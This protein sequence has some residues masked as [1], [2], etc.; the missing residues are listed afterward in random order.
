MTGTP[1]AIN[2]NAFAGSSAAGATGNGVSPG[3]FSS[4]GANGSGGAAGGTSGNPG[5]AGSGSDSGGG[6]GF[7]GTGGQP[8]G[9]TSGNGTL[10]VAAGGGAG[11]LVITYT[12][13]SSTPATIFRP[14]RVITMDW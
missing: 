2:G 10:A 8:G 4:T 6:G 11:E 7:H 5:T 14:N 3:N 9:A 1:G 13:T 12:A